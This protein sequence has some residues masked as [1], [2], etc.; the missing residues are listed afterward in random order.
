MENWTKAV[1]ERR[2]TP[3][4]VD[5]ALRGYS[6]IGKRDVYVKVP[7]EVRSFDFGASAKIELDCEIVIERGK[8]AKLRLLDQ[9]VSSKASQVA[10]EKGAAQMVEQIAR[11][12]VTGVKFGSA[13]QRPSRD[14]GHFHNPYNF[15]PSPEGQ[16]SSESLLG[17]FPPAGHDQY[18]ADLWTGSIEVQLTASTPVLILDTANKQMSGPKRDHP[19]FAPLK[20]NGKAHIPVT[21]LKGP[22]RA[23]Y[24]AITV[25]RFPTWNGHEEKL[26]RR[27]GSREGLLQVPMRV[28]DCGEYFE[29]MVGTHAAAIKNGDYAAVLPTPAAGEPPNKLAYAANL[30]RYRPPRTNEQAQLFPMRYSDTN[31]VPEHF[32]ECHFLAEEYGKYKKNFKSG[33]PDIL[34][35]YW[36]IKKIRKNDARFGDAVLGKRQVSLPNEDGHHPTGAADIVA[37]GFVCITN[38][39]IGN[40]HDEKVFFSTSDPVRIKII[41]GDRDSRRNWKTLAKSYHEEAKKHIEKRG[42][43]GDAAAKVQQMEAYHGNKVGKFAFSRHVVRAEVYGDFELKPQSLLFGRFDDGGK[44]IGVYPVQ[45][46]RELSEEAPDAFLPENIK[47]ATKRKDL[48]PA[49]RVFGW[50]SQEKGAKDGTNMHRGQLRFRS[51]NFQPARPGDTGLKEFNAL[52]L[53]ILGQPKPQ[54]FG[55][56]L[57]G[58]AAGSPLAEYRP[59]D[60]FYSGNHRKNGGRVRGRKVYPHHKA[61]AAVTPYWNPSGQAKEQLVGP[62][63][64]TFY[65]EFIHPGSQEDRTSN[66]NR[67]ITG[68]IAPGAT[69]KAIIDVVN[70]ND[71]ELGAL[72]WLLMQGDAHLRLGYGK[73]LG[74][75]SM[76]TQITGGALQRGRDLADEYRSLAAVATSHSV[77]DDR[78]PSIEEYKKAF[79]VLFNDTAHFDENPVIKAYLA[80]ARGFTSGLPVHYPRAKAAP[81]DNLAGTVVKDLK[82]AVPPSPDGENFNWFVSNTKKKNRQIATLRLLDEGGAP[83]PYLYYKPAPNGQRGRQDGGQRRNHGNHGNHGNNNRG[84]R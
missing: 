60:D 50:V 78:H 3:R 61:A 58:D 62:D 27:M 44:L 18:H 64:R 49:D 16:P 55:F 39:N 56:Y 4:S 37:K 77:P 67:S 13:K 15:I 25:S 31:G 47:P 68:W 28:S 7:E 83:L 32:D 34:Y 20:R 21:S 73:P 17:H 42:L 75:G 59:K 23:A 57:G 29:L 79:V 71:A 30:P 9:S 40:K 72:I 66:Q 1:L 5:W 63:E 11:Q 24:E 46:S 19:V 52:P 53:T 36:K 33:M 6:T 81:D 2:V 35:K 26:A 82:P 84:R 41:D 8:L 80:S 48:S 12:T 14:P 65:R 51:I 70:L 22:L 74:F 45:I 76:A 43:R 38:Q 69:F 54:Q 10:A